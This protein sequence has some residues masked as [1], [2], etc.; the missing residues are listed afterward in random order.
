ME[1]IQIKLLNFQRTKG[2]GGFVSIEELGMLGRTNS[3]ASKFII[4]A[5]ETF[6]KLGVFLI[7]LHSQCRQNYFEI[8]AGKA[9]VAGRTVTTF[10]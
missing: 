9:R 8:E 3:E 6:R 1:E 10:L 5:A 2:R 4:D 7:G